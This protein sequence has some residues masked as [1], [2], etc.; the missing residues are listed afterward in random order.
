MQAHI[1]RLSLPPLPLF[2]FHNVKNHQKIQAVRHIK[3]RV[4]EQLR[5]FI[6]SLENRIFMDKKLLCCLFHIFIVHQ[7]TPEGVRQLCFVFLIVTQ[8]RSQKL[9]AHLHDFR[10]FVH[11]A[12]LL[13][14]IHG[15]IK[16]HLIFPIVVPSHRGCRNAW[17]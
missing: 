8:H 12:Q 1:R 16:N 14:K 5:E 6:L 10:L 3:G 9:M 4:A 7:Q 2:L 11:L 13:E 17:V 15:V